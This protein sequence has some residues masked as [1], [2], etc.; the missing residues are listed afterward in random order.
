M[1]K[2]CRLQVNNFDRIKKGN[3]CDKGLGIILSIY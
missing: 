1:K 2:H 3:I